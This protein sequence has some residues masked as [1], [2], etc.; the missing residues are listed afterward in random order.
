MLYDMLYGI[1]ALIKHKLLKVFRDRPLRKSGSLIL[2]ELKP[3]L[4]Y[5]MDT[6]VALL[7][8]WSGTDEVSNYAC[9]KYPT[10]PTVSIQLC[11]Y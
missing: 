1:Y 5:A 8:T 6:L 9:T 4:L 3:S 11:L 7:P 2:D 10:M